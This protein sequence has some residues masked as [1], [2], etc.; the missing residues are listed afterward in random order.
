MQ[1]LPP[2]SQG[3]PPPRLSPQDS[4]AAT[5]RALKALTELAADSPQRQKRILDAG[6]VC[7]AKQV[8]LLRHLD[9]SAS[10]PLRKHA[11][12]LLKLL[13]THQSA[14]RAV[15]ADARFLEWLEA[16]AGGGSDDNKSR[17]Y[18]RETLVMLDGKG[19]RYE[20]GVFLL[21]PAH[22]PPQPVC[23]LSPAAASAFRIQVAPPMLLVLAR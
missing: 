14:P 16:C 21:D 15:T 13:I 8:I 11:L 23:H 7:L 17:S 19:P 12:R 18:A 2:P 10:A 5:C 1:P 9:P 20:D 6:G 3:K 4:L 22:V